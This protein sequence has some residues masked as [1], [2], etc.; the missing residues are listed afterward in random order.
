MNIDKAL[1]SKMIKEKPTQDRFMSKVMPE[2]NTGCWIWTASTNIKGY[3]QFGIG[4]NQ[5]CV[6]SHRVAYEMFKGPIP[7]KM[8]VLHY[9]D[10]TWCVNPDHLWLGTNLD[11]VKDRLRKGRGAKGITNSRAKLTELE[12]KII[13]ETHAAG[14]SRT[15]IS[16]YFKMSLTAMRN[17]IDRINWKH[18]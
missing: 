14:F 2:P 15:A 6:T 3:G 16:R 9:C 5:N 7:Q 10:N 1:V 13:R 8:H 4:G 17:I 12:V 18:I 11:N